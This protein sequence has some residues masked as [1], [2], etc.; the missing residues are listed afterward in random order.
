MKTTLFKKRGTLV[1]GILNI[2]PD[3][4]SDGG[5][6][7]HN[8]QSAVAKAYLMIKAGADIIDVGGESTRPGSVPVGAEDEM[9]RVLP[10]I[11]KI[12]KKFGRKIIISIDTNKAVVADAAIRAGANMVN[13]LGGFSFDSDLAKIVAYHSVPVVLYHI[14][15]QPKNMQSGE[16]QYGNVVSEIN[17]FFKNQVA[18]G[19]KFGV[20]KGQYILDPGIGFG[21]SVEH[22]ITIIKEFKSF[23]KLRTPLLIGVS[24][25]SHLG[26]IL[27][28][29]LGLKNIPGDKE[30][31]EAGLAETA[32]A[33]M[34]GASI[35]RTHDVLQTKKFLAVLD[36]LL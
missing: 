28:R 11:Q 7:F 6:Y 33:V 15:G 2:T 30:R 31:L 3:S 10:V 27:Q 21:K 8:V 12:R 34:H 20:T 32:V 4:F 14:K 5:L 36:E 26:K 17:Q 35:V 29:K 13:A 23:A 25:K 22:N 9:R 1:M 18:I 24:R 16:I 19:Q